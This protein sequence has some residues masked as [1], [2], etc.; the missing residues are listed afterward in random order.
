MTV[1]LFWH[2]FDEKYRLQSSTKG[3]LLEPQCRWSFCRTSQSP[4]VQQMQC[5]ALGVTD[6]K[7]SHVEAIW[8]VSVCEFRCALQ[9]APQPSP[10][11]LLLSS[12]SSRTVSIQRPRY[13]GLFK[14]SPVFPEASHLICLLCQFR[15]ASSKLWSLLITQP[16]TV[17]TNRTAGC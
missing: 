3:R 5:D 16:Q 13:S 11:M 15:F 12:H 1:F 14:V 17:A 9:S 2:D 10:A 4:P 6:C 7:V 8:G